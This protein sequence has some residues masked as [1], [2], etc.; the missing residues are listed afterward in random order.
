VQWWDNHANHSPLAV[1]HASCKLR[2]NDGVTH[3]YFLTHPCMGEK[4][5]AEKNLIHIPVADFHCVFEPGQEYMFVKILSC[6]PYQWRMDRRIGETVPTHDGRG[7]T[8]LR[9]EATLRHFENVRELRTGQEVSEAMLARH[10][11]LGRTRFFDQNAK[12]E[13]T[14]EYPVTCMNARKSDGRWQVDTGPVLIPDFSLQPRLRVGLFRQGF[15]VYNSFDWAELATRVPCKTE[16]GDVV[17]CY[18]SPRRLVVL[19]QL[20]AAEV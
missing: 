6:Q 3:E 11:I 4:L 12:T 19:N 8:I 13:I 7:A 14:S 15:L 10:P 9:M 2:G 16:S 1:L 18:N 17:M 20:F 5:Y